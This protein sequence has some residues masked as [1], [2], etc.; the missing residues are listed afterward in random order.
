MITIGKELS[1][2]I[3]SFKI[4]V[5]TYEDITVGA[6]PQM[7]KG[8]LQLF[9]ESL[10]FDMES[11]GF[12]D[13]T[14]LKEWRSTFKAA[15]TD[16]SKY[17]P[18]VEALYRRVKKG[19]FIISDNSAID[20]NN[21]FSLEYEIPFG[22]YNL[23]AISEPITVKIG[24]EE[25]SYDALNGRTVSMNEKIVTSDANGSFGSPIV[26]SKRTKVTEDTKNALQVVYF[27]PS[28]SVEN[29][30]QMLRAVEKM[31]IQVHGGSSSSMQVIT[32]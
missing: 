30:T 28:T 22:I 14:G 16:P 26:D 13:F 19:D 3:P 18:S 8:R 5:I 9:Q 21:F 11:K 12:T 10:M 6:T 7:L 27:T 20:V 23:D 15:G 25:D 31:F 29:A 24:T 2:R 4:G 32:S 1:E 17:R